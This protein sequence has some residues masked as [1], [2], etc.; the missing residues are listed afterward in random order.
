MNRGD[1]LAGNARVTKT[2]SGS[3]TQKSNTSYSLQAA[4]RTGAGPGSNSNEQLDNDN[5]LPQMSGVNRQQNMSN[6]SK[7]IGRTNI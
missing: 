6:N 5:L 3:R 4:H 1:E 7:R 2:A